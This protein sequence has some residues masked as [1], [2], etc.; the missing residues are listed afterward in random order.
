M[1]AFNKPDETYLKWC[2][3]KDNDIPIVLKVKG[4]W[5]MRS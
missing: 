2:D 1:V 4:Q 3:D 5:E